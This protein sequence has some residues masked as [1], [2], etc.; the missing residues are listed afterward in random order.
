MDPP[1]AEENKPGILYNICNENLTENSRSP[2][3]NSANLHE[4][5]DSPPQNSAVLDENLACAE[6][7]ILKWDMAS[8]EIA[9]QSMIFE[10]QREEAE[11]YLNTVDEVQKLMD[12]VSLSQNSVNKAQ[13]VLQMA[14]A[15]LEEEFRHILV[16]HSEPLDPDLVFNPASMASFRSSSEG[17]LDHPSNSSDEDE[18]NDEEEYA[19]SHP[20]TEKICEIDL[21]PQDVIPDLHSIAERMVSAGYV[22]ECVQVYGSIRKSMVDESLYRLGIERLSIGDVQ[23]LDWETLE[24][25]IK[26]WIQAAKVCVR[27]LF[28]SEKRM[29]EQVFD[30]L[31]PVEKTCFAE[32]AKG[33]TLQLFNFSEAIAISRRSPEK[34]FKILDLYE[35]LSELLP[36]IEIV[37]SSDTCGSVK[38]QA[39]EIL[40]RLGEAAR[41]IFTEFENAIQRETS[42]TPIPGGTIHPLTRYVMNYI[43]FLSDYK[44]TL[45]KLIVN[46]PSQSSKFLPDVLMDLSRDYDRECESDNRT[47]LSLHLVWITIILQCNLDGKSKLYKDISLSHLFMMNNVHYIVQKVKAS[48]LRAL[49]GD[50]WLRKHSGKVRQYAT[51]YQRATWI[52]VLSCLRDEGIHVSGS[53]SSGVSKTAL[54]ERFKSFNAAFDEVHRSQATWLVPD[55]QLR[56]EL[57][58]SIAEKLLPAYRSFLGRFRNH[59]ESGRH[60]EMYI[61]YT[62]ED[63]ESSL[64]D[65]FEGSPVSM[66]VRRRSH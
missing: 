14:M 41:G 6:N 26:K 5:L 25:K 1:G 17:F 62:P 22:R 53:F 56:E 18:A 7:L 59:L 12:S 39:S 34:L 8:S 9:R 20:I 30:G 33:A 16:V 48:D 2:S 23:R 40:T 51:N 10:G 46:K 58:I 29:C 28:A 19:V 57:R 43:S 63:L 66:H 61:K 24:L 50:D 15:R 13:N 65:L 3:E 45:M 64:L 31:I 37:F 38:T 49:I 55:P 4:N 60:S 52:K 35:A 11:N 36:D 27:M 54:K 21:I 32:L 47:V 42:K 44:D